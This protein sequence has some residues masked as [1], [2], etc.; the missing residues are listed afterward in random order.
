MPNVGC[1]CEFNPLHNGHLSLLKRMKEEAGPDGTA[2]CA[3]SGNAVQRAE[4]PLF[5][6]A[7]R[8][9]AALECGADLVMELPFPWCAAPTED[10]ALCGIRI[11]K[12]LGTD[13]LMFGSECGDMDRLVSLS[14]AL[15]TRFPDY[16]EQRRRESP[17]LGEARLT[18]E[19]LESSE[20]YLPGPNDRLGM[21]YLEAL[22][23]EAP[24]MKALTLMREP[25]SP[26]SPSAT[27]LRNRIRQ[28]RNLY[29]IAAFVP[30]N[31]LPFY[32][33]ESE[34]GYWS[35]SEGLGGVA[36]PILLF[37]RIASE[38]ILRGL[39]GMDSGL[40]KRIRK[41][42]SMA[43][44]GESFFAALKTKRYTDAHLRR[45]LLFGLTGVRASDCSDLPGYTRLIGANERGLR[46]LARIKKQESEI[47]VLSKPAD[48]PSGIR[49]R[50]QAEFERKLDTLYTLQLSV[51]VPAETGKT[52]SPVIV[53]DTG[54]GE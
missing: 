4:F 31:V 35:C 19:F 13:I 47:P 30:G 29:G 36:T 46:Q 20:G 3:M 5:N 2:I 52:Q 37:Y 53:L 22:R 27:A 17:S 48:I 9:R 50:K 10:Y 41:A 39:Y 12:C 42:A 23:N 25:L 11:L 49:A 51:P 45:V 24:D 26:S 6:R 28:D 34:S 7:A 14:N 43:P 40:E 15:R 38:E 8:A 21:A 32:H 33:L 1:I 54:S 18:A 44:D 16:R